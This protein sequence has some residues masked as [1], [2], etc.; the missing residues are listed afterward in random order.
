MN[1]N[2]K[3]LP[4]WRSTSAVVEP[5]AI[6]TEIYQSHSM[7]IQNRQ[8]LTHTYLERGR[9]VALEGVPATWP[10]LRWVRLAARGEAYN[11]NSSFGM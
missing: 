9:V 8:H 1:L 5:S 11:N 4:G 3:S 6:M 7:Y 10:T 2:I